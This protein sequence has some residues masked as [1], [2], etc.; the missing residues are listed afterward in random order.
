M[1]EVRC[2]RGISVMFRRIS[3][4]VCPSVLWLPRLLCG[5]RGCFGNVLS[6]HDAQPQSYYLE[7]VCL[8][9]VRLMSV[10]GQ[11]GEYEGHVCVHVLASVLL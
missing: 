10:G 5:C 7:V 2:D 3:Q 1:K 6:Q 11:G 9:R 8:T 4:R